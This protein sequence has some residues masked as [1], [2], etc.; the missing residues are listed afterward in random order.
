MKIG[1]FLN[2]EKSVGGGH[3]WR[4]FN[5]AKKLKKTGRDFYFFSNIKNKFFL[6][7]LKK[8]N[9]KHI[10]IFEKDKKKLIK[11]LIEKNT[12]LMISNLIIDNYKINFHDEK[13][14]KT[15]IKRLIVIDDHDNKRH[16]CDLFI[17]NNFL[18]KESKKK[19][20]ENNPKI[21]LAIGHNYSIVNNIKAQK[22][23]IFK[24]S[25]NIKNIFV[26]FGSS[27]NTNET[28]KIL[29]IVDFFPLIKF[30]II[31]GNFN[32]NSLKF[33]KIEK[34]K[35]NIKFYFNLNN[36]KIINLIKKND[37]AIGAGGVNMIERLYFNLPSFVICVANNQ[38]KGTE[39]LH[40]AKSVLYLGKSKNVSSQKIKDNLKSLINDKKR[41]EIFKKNTSKISLNLNSKNLITK[42]LNSILIK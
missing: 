24:R 2:F 22:N 26:F 33:K 34:T 29:K 9:F 41:F 14:I 28:S 36:T 17:N 3:F 8:N 6:T 10:E 1:F 40:N 18:S 12:Y 30:N 32:K 19:I 23:L 38:K 11:K 16:Y 21:N 4:C 15:V 7:M 20:K 37:L 5:L 39:Y 13:K 35:K 25:K 27:D 31:I 42:K